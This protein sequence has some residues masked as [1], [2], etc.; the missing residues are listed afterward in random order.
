MISLKAANKYRRIPKSVYKSLCWV[1][2]TVGLY[3]LAFS[4]SWK[5][6]RRNSQVSVSHHPTCEPVLSFLLRGGRETPRG[7]PGSSLC[8]SSQGRG[9]AAAAEA[10]GRI[11]RKRSV[12][13]R[14]R[15]LGSQGIPGAC[16][17]LFSPR[18][19]FTVTLE[20]NSLRVSWGRTGGAI[21]ARLGN[22]CVFKGKVLWVKTMSFPEWR[23]NPS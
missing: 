23:S 3:S 2:F 17:P 11:C 12:Q 22:P 19:G 5:I 6:P 10:E 15:P 9:W 1:C 13:E 4:Y 8:I 16:E 21:Q 18:G 20:K 14:T 7:G